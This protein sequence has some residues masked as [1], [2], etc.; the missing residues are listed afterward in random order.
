MN[1]KCSVFIATSF[2]GFIAG[3]KG[4]ISW[5]ENPDYASTEPP[6]LSYDDFINTVDGIVMGR[7]TFEKV[8]TFGFWPYE[9]TPVF[10]L[11]SR[12]LKIPD[13]LNGKV[14][15][16]SGPPQEIVLR[17]AKKGKK[18]LYID[19]GVTIQ[20]FFNDGLISELTITIVPVLLGE[21]IPLFS[22][23]LPKQLRLMD[24]KSASN[25]FVQ[26]RYRVN[27]QSL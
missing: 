26:V 11:T 27:N 3:L 12:K 17:L 9:K 2:D 19:G 1:L 22:K 18:H 5:L 23:S 25:G 13:H 10:V 20:R 7:N 6:G 14:H 8:L 15:I 4:D 24:T 16:E 21:G